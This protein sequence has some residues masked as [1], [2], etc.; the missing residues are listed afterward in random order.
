LR[1]SAKE[2][3]AVFAAASL[4]ISR[5]TNTLTAFSRWHLTRENLEG[6][7]SRQAI[8]MVWD[9]CEGNP[10]SESTGSLEGAIEWVSA[11]AEAWSVK[12]LLGQVERADCAAVPLADEAASIWFTD[13]PYYDS[14]PYAHLSDVFYVWLKRAIGARLPSL[15]QTSLTPK[16]DECVVDRPHSAS[17]SKKTPQYYEAKMASAMAEGRRV[18]R[19]DGIG[20]VVFAHKS[21]EGWEAL[22]AGIRDAGWV[23]TA[24]WP[25]VTEMATRNNARDTASLAASV[26]LVCRPRPEDAPVG[27][28]AEVLGELP[29]RVGDWMERLQTEGVR[30][31]DLV[32]ACVGPALEIFSR[33]PKVETAEGR[34]VRLPEFL[35]QDA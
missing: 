20:C 35:N 24:S 34:E 21:T 31:A 5:M 16:D 15:F 26:H 13:P 10:L 4:C 2:H 32:F 19:N 27:D 14:V 28:W 18:L 30:G 11:T 9:F 33:Y 7:F 25:I 6:I 1:Q 3:P 29:R 12:G 8:G 17:D 23:L 22:L